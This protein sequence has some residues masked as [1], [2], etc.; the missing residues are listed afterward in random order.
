LKELVGKGTFGHVYKVEG[1]NGEIRAMKIIDIF[2]S[3][4]N[5][6]YIE[7]IKREMEISKK[8]GVK[9]CPFIVKIYDIF[10]DSK[11]FYVIMEYC[12]KGNLSNYLKGKNNFRLEVCFFIEVI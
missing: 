10:E 5:N 12:E 1:S 11:I 8:L 2:F 6:K 9:E 7:S 4:E 3:E